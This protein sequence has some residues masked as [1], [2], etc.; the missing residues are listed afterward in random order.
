[1]KIIAISLA[2]TGFFLSSLSACGD[3]NDGGINET[4]TGFN[5]NQ[6]HGFDTPYV[7]MDNDR[8]QSRTG[9]WNQ[10][11]RDDA[12]FQSNA[13]NSSWRGGT[14]VQT[15]EYD[16][17]G[18]GFDRGA[19]GQQERIRGQRAQD[20]MYRRSGRLNMDGNYTD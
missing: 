2:A 18:R 8:R 1:M 10:R 16:V 15:R 5:T 11:R 6:T 12:H 13:M 17:R 3:M 4:T 9:I 19:K 20:D 7:E 14:H